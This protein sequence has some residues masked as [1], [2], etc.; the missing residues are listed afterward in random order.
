GDDEAQAHFMAVGT[1]GSGKTIILRLLMQSVLPDV[2]MGRGV[3]AIVYDAKQD[4]LPILAGFCDPRLIFTLN[5]FDDRGVAWDVAKDITEP[6]VALE[7]AFTLVPKTNEQNPFF[8]DASRDIIYGIVLSFILSKQPWSL[9]D[10]IRAASNPKTAHRVLKRHKE[11]AQYMSTYFADKRLCFN[12][13][14]TIATKLLDFRPVAGCWEAATR[15][16]SLTEFFN[17]EMILVLGNCEESKKSLDAIN[18]LIFKRATDMQLAKP[19]YTSDR[20]WYFLDEL[21]EAGKLDG[22]VSLMKKGRSKGARVAIAFQTISGLRDPSNFGQYMADE[23][24]GQIGCRFFGRIECPE[25]AEFASK[26][27]GGRELI[28][29]SNSQTYGQHGS[30]T[31]SYQNIISRTMLP[32]EFLSMPA[33]TS[34]N[35]LFGIVTLRNIGCTTIHVHPVDL[36]EHMLVSPEPNVPDFVPRDVSHQYMP[37]WT[38]EQREQFAPARKKGKGTPPL[39]EDKPKPKTSKSHLNLDDLLD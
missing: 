31:H 25:T 4:A 39:T 19:E 7:L 13:F 14:S 11:S 6:R 27:L 35:G 2:G 16:I 22:L 32:S 28:Q 24:V 26:T 17:S 36:F 15:R 38:P 20:T 9:A 34:E 12:I 5:P 37:D 21:T 29:K 30:T 10:V 33:C 18:R 23:V 3:R 1:I 8:A